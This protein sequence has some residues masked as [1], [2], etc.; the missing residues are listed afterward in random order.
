MLL[1]GLI[2]RLAKNQSSLELTACHQASGVIEYVGEKLNFKQPFWAG[3][4]PLY[5]FDQDDE[6]PYPFVF[7]P[8]ELGEATLGSLFWYVLEGEPEPNHIDPSVF[9]FMAYQPIL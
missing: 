1:V 3:E 8:L 5:D 6:D 7:H 9:P 4:H 2:L